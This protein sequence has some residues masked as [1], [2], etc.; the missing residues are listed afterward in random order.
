VRSGAS[1]TV[2][3]KA[4][5]ADAIG[6]NCTVAVYQGTEKTAGQPGQTPNA[7]KAGVSTAAGTADVK[8]SNNINAGTTYTIIITTDKGYVAK[9]SFKATP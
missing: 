5:G 7:T 3:W 2:K 1:F 9:F 8:V 6:P 4:I